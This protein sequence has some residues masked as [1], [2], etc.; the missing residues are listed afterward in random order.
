MNTLLF[1]TDKID[2]YFR[3]ISESSH[4]TNPMLNESHQYYSTSVE[5]I[6]EALELINKDAGGLSGKKF[7]DAG[8]GVGIICG[9]ARECGLDSFGIEI[10]PILNDASGT[11]FPE[12]KFYNVDIMNF[13]EY[14]NFDIVFYFIPFQDR[15]IQLK[16]KKKIEND[17][18]IG[19]YII[20]F[21]KYY[22]NTKSETKDER[23]IGIESENIV[24]KIWKKICK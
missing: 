3:K 21:D 7:I 20:S 8:C 17:I 23:F 14:S 18:N 6:V 24:N 22:D 11:M 16:F 5:F 4:K 9:I 15:D 12:V 19:S 13:N 10:N 2:I 1:L